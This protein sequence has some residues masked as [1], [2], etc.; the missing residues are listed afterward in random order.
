MTLHGTLMIFFV[1]TNAPFAAFGTYFL[2]LQ[3]GARNMAFP[4]CSMISFWTTFASFLVLVS[5][6]FVG[7]GPPLSG[8]T[9]YPPLSADGASSGSG[10]GLGQTLWIVSIALFSAASI[11]NSINFIATTLD[12]R[13]RGMT[14]MR[15]P[16]STWGWFITAFM[17]L[18]AFAVLLP[19][20]VLTPDGPRR[21]NKL[22]RTRAASSSTTIS[23]PTRE[24]FRSCGS[25]CSGSSDT[26]KCTSRFCRRSASCP[27]C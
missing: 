2:P 14:L 19:A 5:T 6:F 4:R 9:A 16:L 10:E 15:M 7:D 12:L 25:I 11:L 1:L 22:L 17:A 3:I 21:G 13:G 20:C 18:L 26:R 23:S 24:A 8:W 27:M